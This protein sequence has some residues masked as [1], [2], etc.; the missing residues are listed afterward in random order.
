MSV[1]EKVSKETKDIQER[2]DVPERPAILFLVQEF[3]D[4]QFLK[5]ETKKDKDASEDSIKVR[6][7]NQCAKL[8]E[9][10]AV[11]VLNNKFEDPAARLSYILLHFTHTAYIVN[12]VLSDAYSACTNVRSQTTVFNE[13]MRSIDWGRLSVFSF[14]GGS[15]SDILGVLMWLHRFGFNARVTAATADSCQQWEST[16]NNVF[17][18]MQFELPELSK[19]APNP[20]QKYTHNLWRKLDG[21]I[22]FFHS[23]L[24]KP[25]ALFKPASKELIAVSQ[26][27]L[28]TF[29]FVISGLTDSSD[30]SHAIQYVLD[31]MK[32][33]AV[34]V[35]IDF[36]EGSHTELV[37][38]LAYWCGLRRIY[39][40][41]E[42]E[43]ELPEYEKAE[44][45]QEYTKEIGEVRSG[46]VTAIVYKKPSGYSFDR[47]ARI[48][49]RE[50]KN[51][52]Q[53]QIRLKK[54]N[55][56]FKLFKPS[57]Y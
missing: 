18:M 32:P 22:K 25:D 35:Y 46:K 5:H 38:N 1:M 16:M 48:G 45:L 50:S 17:K 54:K 21:G 40:M 56:D 55:P 53:A 15:G 49:K 4:S 11:C 23:S 47:K 31:S 57:Y 39:Y 29:P 28:I 26:A 52:R 37:N 42:M 2:Q 3:L 51:I 24:N 33:G 30:A 34:L 12:S 41:K 8:N 9:D 7:S 43:Y 19:E 27:D 14:G 6:F 20:Q 44:F 36:V 10:K 13:M